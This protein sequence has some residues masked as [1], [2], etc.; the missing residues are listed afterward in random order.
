MFA[1]LR[2]GSS[3][4]HSNCSLVCCDQ[5]ECKVNKKSLK[6]GEREENSGGIGDVVFKYTTL[7]FPVTKGIATGSREKGDECQMKGGV[8]DRK[9]RVSSFF[10]LR[11]L[12][13][14]LSE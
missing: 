11:D 5:S 8:K 7:L 3:S 13:G 12:W 14:P 4:L 2:P 10:L 9:H 1:F 6:T